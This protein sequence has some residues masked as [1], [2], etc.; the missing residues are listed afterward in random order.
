M[1]GPIC[2]TLR[3]PAWTSHFVWRTLQVLDTNS[4]EDSPRP[5]ENSA[6]LD[7]ALPAQL[8]EISGIPGCTGV[9]PFARSGEHNLTVPGATELYGQQRGLCVG[10]P[11][12]RLHRGFRLAQNKHEGCLEQLLHSFCCRRMQECTYQIWVDC[13]AGP[14]EPN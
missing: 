9:L 2:S 8:K 13:R 6:T 12:R 14:E 11:F 5:V 1:S 10:C 7:G 3:Q 4:F